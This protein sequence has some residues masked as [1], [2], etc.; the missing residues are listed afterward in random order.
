MSSSLQANNNENVENVGNVGNVEKYETVENSLKEVEN[1]TVLQDKFY[2]QAK[3]LLQLFTFP[4]VHINA[5]MNGKRKVWLQTYVAL[6]FII[7][8]HELDGNSC[9]E[10]TIQS[11][12]NILTY[13]KNKN[14]PPNE[15][16]V[17]LSRKMTVQALGVMLSPS[18]NA[19]ERTTDKLFTLDVIDVIR[20]VIG[21]FLLIDKK[22]NKNLLIELEEFRK[23]IKGHDIRFF[24]SMNQELL[25]K[26][27][28]VLD[29]TLW[30]EYHILRDVPIQKALEDESETIVKQWL[31]VFVYWTNKYITKSAQEER[32]D[33]SSIY[34]PL[35][36]D[37][38]MEKVPL[39]DSRDN[40]QKSISSI[41]DIL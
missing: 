29:Q 13:L 16:Y 12:K 30:I 36:V 40:L 35:S 9:S 19:T 15:S 1:A 34:L 17:D 32:V 27:V 24:C 22:M 37:S 7:T 21:Y 38:F 31:D 25:L 6:C 2:K 39:H 41:Q 8:R 4:D 11:A 33:K 28:H 26:Y 20:N 3:I 18:S 5:T 23:F 10:E 14:I